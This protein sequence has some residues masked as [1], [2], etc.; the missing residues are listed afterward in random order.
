MSIVLKCDHKDCDQTGVATS[1]RS[2]GSRRQT[3]MTEIVFNDRP[4]GSWKVVESHLFCWEHGTDLEI[5][6]RDAQKEAESTILAAALSGES[7]I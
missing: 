5:A 4:G 2:Y 6:I 3:S 1:I 7:E